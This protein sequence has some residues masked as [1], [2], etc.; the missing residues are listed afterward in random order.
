[1]LMLLAWNP[2]LRT[3]TLVAVIATRTEP[4]RCHTKGSQLWLHIRITWG[5]LKTY[6]CPG[7]TSDQLIRI[8]GDGALA[9]SV[10]PNDSTCNQG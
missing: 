9:V 7:P 3:T 6:E 5:N 2:T 4:A 1:M 10:F 8:S